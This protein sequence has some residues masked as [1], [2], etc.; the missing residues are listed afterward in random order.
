[1]Y[2][3]ESSSRMPLSLETT[4]LGKAEIQTSLAALLF[5]HGIPT[6]VA[7]TPSPAL[8]VR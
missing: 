4:S 1:M 2:V 8:R 7:M 5:I 6:P 3:L